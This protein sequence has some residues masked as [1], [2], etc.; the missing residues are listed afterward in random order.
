MSI[1]RK[2]TNSDE[3][4]RLA[5]DTAKEKKDNTPAPD[6]VLT[7]GTIARLD[8][9]QPIFKQAMQG[10]DDALAA[11]GQ[12]T[13]AKNIAQA[14]AKM[15]ISHFIQVFNLGVERGVFAKEERA[16][17]HLD[18]NSS[19]VPSLNSEADIKQWGKWLIEGDARRVA[20]GGAPMG[21]PTIAEVETV[22]NN[23]VNLNNAQSTAKDAYDKAQEVVSNMRDDVDALILRI[24]NEVETAYDNETIESK[25]RNARE[26]GVV[27]VSTQKA[28]ITGLVTN[29]STGAPLENVNVSIVEEGDVVQ[30]N[31]NGEYTLSTNFTGEGTLE[32]SLEGFTTQTFPVTIEE[33]ATLI[34]DAQLQPV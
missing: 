12:A 24:W 33:G 20:A 1:T 4:R 22:C 8:A 18:I 16:Y 10:R 29:A 25:R 6:I 28:K 14:L 17:L 5:L 3:G 26:W 11:Q 9:M 31:A 13:L 30:T 27:Y 2:L 19:S 32:F 23:F 15:F 7:S 34:Q 21:F